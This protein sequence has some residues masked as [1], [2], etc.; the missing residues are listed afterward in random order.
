M[1]KSQRTL[2]SMLD[3]FI[4][5]HSICG[6]F[7]FVFIYICVCVPQSESIPQFYCCLLCIWMLGRKQETHMHSIISSWT[8]KKF[9]RRKSNNCHLGRSS[10]SNDIFVMNTT[11]IRLDNKH[12]EENK[13]NDHRRC[14]VSCCYFNIR[15][16]NSNRCFQVKNLW[17]PINQSLDI[18]HD[19]KHNKSNSLTIL[20]NRCWL[21]LASIMMKTM[22]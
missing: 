3:F 9:E 22:S 14:L 21:C 15:N 2:R 20:E 5:V 17:A 11:D 6:R 12:I 19:L 13:R 16:K 8:E 10:D 1:A 7:L 18:Q 4:F